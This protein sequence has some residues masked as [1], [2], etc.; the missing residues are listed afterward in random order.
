MPEGHDDTV[1]CFQ[2]GIKVSGWSNISDS[3]SKVHIGQSPNCQWALL[4]S[5][6]VAWADSYESST[7]K[8][9]P[10]KGASVRDPVAG[11]EPWSE[12]MVKAREDTFKFGWW[13]YHNDPNW[14][15]SARKVNSHNTFSYSFDRSNIKPRYFV[16]I[17]VGRNW[18]VLQPKARR[19]R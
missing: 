5:R 8:K 2:C 9:K 18:N 17:I 3:P 10:K 1:S 6:G 7:S 4:F 12:I 13:P 11:D 16:S 14:T 15:C 19:D